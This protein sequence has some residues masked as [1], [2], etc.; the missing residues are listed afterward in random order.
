MNAR[1]LVLPLLLVTATSLEAQCRR[2]WWGRDCRGDDDRHVRRSSRSSVEF[3]VRGGYD[4]DAEAGTAGAQVRVPLAAGLALVPSADVWL[5]EAPTDWQINADVMLRPAALG[6]LYGGA[7][8]AFVHADFDG[9]EDEGT[10]TGYNLFVGIAGGRVGGSTVRPFAE[11]RWTHVE[12]DKGF[13]LSVG[14]DVP[15]R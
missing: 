15:I 14:I 2:T 6:G 9:D 1:W 13:R 12:D 3:G 11:G 5:E 7:G 8:A 10:E 4:F